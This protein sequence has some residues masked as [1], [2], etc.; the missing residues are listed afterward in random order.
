LEKGVPHRA[1]KLDP[2]SSRRMRKTLLRFGMKLMMRAMSLIQMSLDIVFA[3][4]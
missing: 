2:K 3:I 4:V 1:R